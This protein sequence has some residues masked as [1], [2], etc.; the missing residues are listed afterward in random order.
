[1]GRK[2]TLRIH[3]TGQ[4]FFKHAGQSH[5]CGKD[6]ATAAATFRA[7][8]A[9]LD[10]AR[11]GGASA[12]TGAT[13]ARQ[14]AKPSARQPVPETTPTVQETA[15]R[16]WEWADAR[17]KAR[18]S[19]GERPHLA[20]FLEVFGNRPIDSIG[21]AELT[22]WANR[23]RRHNG[24]PYA[25]KSKNH[26]TQAARRLLTWAYEAGIIEKPY[27]LATL[28]PV[29]LPS[30]KS[31]AL[32]P[33]RVGEVVR[34]LCGLNPNL[35]RMYLL[36]FWA[37]LRPSE[38]GRVIRRE[39]TREN[40]DGSTLPEGCYRLQVSKTR[41]RVVI[42]TPEAETLLAKIDPQYGAEHESG[43]N[44]AV[45]RARRWLPGLPAIHPM[46]HSAATCM[47]D[48]G[49]S[50]D[51]VEAAL[52]HTLPRVQA[53]YT[54]HPLTLAR[55]SMAILSELVMEPQD[56]KVTTPQER[57]W[58]KRKSEGKPRRKGAK[59]SPARAAA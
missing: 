35:G 17:R 12:V 37:A 19:N 11:A 34:S 4:Y 52:G 22:Q 54:G 44:H 9:A 25:P 20:P 18:T 29:P 24:K 32:K 31:K 38:V 10:G 27:R 8:F 21:L 53:S 13:L 58:A 55:A 23:L 30:P 49:V 5:Y 59:V 41:T 39:W 1:M 7:Y 45:Q 43:L 6:A 42:L 33:A 14:T 16:F 48:A 47:I 3:A 40:A 56:V 46:R 15:L 57:L 2:S 26:Y 28:D 50:R 36:A 51:H